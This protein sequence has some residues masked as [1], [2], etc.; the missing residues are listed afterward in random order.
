MYRCRVLRRCRGMSW[1]LYSSMKTGT[2]LVDDSSLSS[3]NSVSVAEY[4]SD[5]TTPSSGHMTSMM[6][7][8][9]PLP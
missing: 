2:E 9:L 8:D 6:S 7:E 1:G 3:A 4:G 5:E